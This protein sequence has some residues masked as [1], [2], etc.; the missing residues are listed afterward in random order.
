MNLRKLLFAATILII[1]FQ[2]SIINCCAQ[3]TKLY[4]F[5]GGSDGQEPYGSLLSE[6]GFLYGMTKGDGTNS[7]GTIFKI[8]S[9]G[10]GYSKLLDFN[11]VNGS[12]P[13]G[14][15]ISDGSFLYGITQKGGTGTCPGGCGVIFKIKSDGT[16]YSLLHNFSAGNG[17][18]YYP[19]NSLVSD[20]TFLYGMTTSGGTSLQGWGTIFKIKADGTGYSKLFDFDSINGATPQGELI[21]DGTFLY[22]MTTYGGTS[23][24]PQGDGII[25]KIKTDGTGFSKVF[26]FQGY[27]DG[28]RPYG[29]LISD[30]TFLYGMTSNG[31]T[32]HYWYGVGDGVIFKI[33]PD[34]TG[35]SQLYD[36][37][38]HPSGCNP[39]GSL[40]TDGTFLYG[41]TYSGGI[42]DNFVSEGDGIIFKLKPDGTEYSRLYSFAIA[43]NGGRSYGSLITD[44]TFLYGMTSYGGANT[45]GT[46]F[47]YYPDCVSNSA[48]QSIFVCKFGNVHVGSKIHDQTGTYTDVITNLKGCDSILTTY[49]TVNNVS[50]S[51]SYGSQLLTANTVGSPSYQWIDCNNGKTPIAG[52]NSK[53]YTA[54]SSG[55]YAVV[56]SQNGCSDTSSCYY[57]AVAGVTEN[58]FANTINIYPNPFSSQTAVTF[59]QQQKNTTIKIIDVLGKELKSINFT[60]KQSIIEKGEMRPGI[61]FLEIYDENKNLA[62]KKIIV[63]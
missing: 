3:F 14:S 62:N 15:L 41:M 23:P 25:F 52:E 1:S 31:G 37:P 49:L 26:D 61:Y 50:V 30:G 9:D 36:F 17:S 44:G 39:H 24:N 21:T 13:F 22:G 29:S 2:L 48:T 40:I 8:K 60:G 51:G 33:K 28:G 45:F 6:G 4:D 35:Y 10:T 7:L 18:G 43:P 47:K 34:G 56:V 55:S 63:Q 59:T 32:G 20:G 54:T 5:L 46:I 27:P 38:G 12:T 58:N 19:L 53:T 57:I 11:G 16:G 42:G